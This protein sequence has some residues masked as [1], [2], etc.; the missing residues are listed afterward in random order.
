MNH[1]ETGKMVDAMIYKPGDLPESC[2]ETMSFRPRVKRLYV[3]I[4]CRLFTYFWEKSFSF[5]CHKASGHSFL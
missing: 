2:T 1:W 4:V 5:V 3:W